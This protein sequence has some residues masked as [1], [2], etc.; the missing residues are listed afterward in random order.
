MG[1]IIEKD[2]SMEIHEA[3]LNDKSLQQLGAVRMKLYTLCTPTVILR[4]GKSETIW[5]DETNNPQI[6]KINEL[7]ESRRNQIIDWYKPPKQ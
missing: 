2:N 1:A 6:K 7:I 3:L 5:T 4:D